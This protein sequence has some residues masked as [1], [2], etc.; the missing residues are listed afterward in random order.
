MQCLTNFSQMVCTALCWVAT[1]R[2]EVIFVTLLLTAPHL[3]SYLAGPNRDQ[4]QP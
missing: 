2:F 1:G 4:Y 3:Q